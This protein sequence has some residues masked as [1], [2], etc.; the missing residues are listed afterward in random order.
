M[1][2]LFLPYLNDL[3]APLISGAV[4]FLAVQARRAAA[5]FL[6]RNADW[7]DANSL[8]RLEAALDNAISKAEAAGSTADLNVV[9][10]YVKKYNPGD[11]ARLKL[12]GAALVERVKAGIAKRTS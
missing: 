1:W 12:G 9:I 11:L 10:D 4:L 8:Q 6:A 5:S 7:M 3:A 2:N